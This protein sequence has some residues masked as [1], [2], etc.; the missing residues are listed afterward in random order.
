MT[1]GAI[2]IPNAQFPPSRALHAKRPAPKNSADVRALRANP[3]VAT[4]GLSGT[5]VGEVEALCSMRHCARGEHAFHAGSTGGGL[6]VVES[7][8]IKLYAVAKT[9]EEQVLGFCLPGELF[10]LDAL[11]AGVHHCSAVALEACVVHRLPTPA[12]DALCRRTPGLQRRLHQ[13]I[14]QRLGAIHELVM[15][16]GQKSAE[17]RIASFLVD[18]ADRSGA[19][20]LRLGMSRDD[21]GH[22]LGLALETVS[23]LFRRL[24]DDGLIR[25]EGRHVTIENA[26]GLRTLAGMPSAGANCL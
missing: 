13:L 5:A 9:G 24:H 8:V 15:L 10:G 12:L 1:I 20:V 3:F 2:A 19:S 6:Y 11:G 4:L 25:S 18:L 7:G 16:L 17:E 22:Y 14:G 21:I 23:R 26:I